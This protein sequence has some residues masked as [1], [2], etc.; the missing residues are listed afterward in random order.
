M[1]DRSLLVQF[2]SR[3]KIRVVH[4][5]LSGGYTKENGNRRGARVMIAEIILMLC[6]YEKDV[7]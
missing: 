7:Q 4:W 2:L 5:G 3:S 6:G 1:T